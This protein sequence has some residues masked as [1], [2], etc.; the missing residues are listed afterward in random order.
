MANASISGC[1]IAGICTS[2]PSRC[3]DNIKDTSEFT[4]GEVKKMVALAGVST[5]R[6]VDRH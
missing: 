2:V 4:E 1:K 5:R 3:F 6:D